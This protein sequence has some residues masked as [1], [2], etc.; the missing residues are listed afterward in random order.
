MSTNFVCASESGRSGSDIGV[1]LLEY[2][3]DERNLE[4]PEVGRIKWDA[5][6]E[7][8]LVATRYAN[9]PGLGKDI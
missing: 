6:V 1:P 7:F 3:G 8:I 5:G 2:I 4:M 9:D